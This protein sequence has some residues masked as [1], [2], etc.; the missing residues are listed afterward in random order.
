[1][2]HSP[3]SARTNAPASSCHSPPSR[4]AVTVK[5]ALVDPIPVVRTERGTTLAAYFRN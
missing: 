3:P 4:T 5:P 2:Q 1:M